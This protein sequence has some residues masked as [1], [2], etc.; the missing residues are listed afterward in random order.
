MAA[1]DVASTASV[2]KWQVF[3]DIKEARNA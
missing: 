1:K 2:Q 3:R